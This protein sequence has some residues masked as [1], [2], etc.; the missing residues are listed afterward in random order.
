ME[1]QGP[2]QTPHYDALRIKT[3]LDLYIREDWMWTGWF[4]T[5]SLTPLRLAYEDLA[6]NP[7]SVLAEVLTHLGQDPAL[8]RHIPPGT[9]KLADATSADWLRRYRADPPPT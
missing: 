3:Q 5:Q 8:A 6:A 1:R 4:T 9:A 2:P 7:Q